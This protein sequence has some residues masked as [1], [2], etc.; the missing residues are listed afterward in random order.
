MIPVFVL[1]RPVSLRIL[2]QLKDYKGKFG[3]LAHAFTTD[4]FK[5]KFAA[6]GLTDF[7]IGDSGIYQKKPMEYNK[8]FNE[9]EKMHV[10]YGIIKD[11][12]RDPK[13]TLE[14]AKL[15]KSEYNKRKYNFELM[16][17]AQGTTVA[18][19]VRSY[20][21]QRKLFDNVVIGGLLDKIEK[22][23][24][25]VRVKSDVFL[26]NVLH[27]IRVLHPKDYIF[28]LGAFNKKRIE[29]FERENIWASDYKGWI[30]RYNL[31]QSH[32][33]NDRF[34]QTAGNI[35]SLFNFIDEKRETVL[36][37]NSRNKRLLILSC[38]MK[39]TEKPGMA[40]N[41]Y[42]GPYY[43]VLRKYLKHNNGIDIKI[44]SAKYGLINARDKICPYDYKMNKPDALIYRRIY[45][46]EMEEI[47]SLY[48]DVQFCGSKLYGSIIDDKYNIIKV[49]GK[50]GQQ[51]HQLKTWLYYPQTSIIGYE[52]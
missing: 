4:N 20:E 14:S 8:L 18:E 30:F 5:E 34:E 1:D 6:F 22:H 51:L 24:R 19:Y 16:G 44:I 40:F 25:M 45:C 33:N 39:K 47:A 28:P 43:R 42:D 32:K 29:M 31:E 17:V 48:K 13:K 26:G 27:A 41:V 12:Y 38:S 2:E 49:N 50:I 7:K 3:I 35:R 21:E 15:A 11:Y 52:T 23:V 46:S 36:K 10:K 9:Y 37:N